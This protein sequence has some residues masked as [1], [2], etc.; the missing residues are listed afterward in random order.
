M[1]HKAYSQEGLMKGR[2]FI[3]LLGGAAA[4]ISWPLAARAQ[5]PSRIV[6]IGHIESGMP[7][8]SPNLLAAFRQRLRELGY[9]E[10]KNLFIEHRYAEGREERRRRIKSRSCLSA[11]ATRSK[12]AWSR[13]W[14]TLAAM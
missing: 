13:A 3:T 8:S 5:Q 6:K 1:L 9:V 2:E 4:S 14:P 12:S 7:S 11:V 10:G